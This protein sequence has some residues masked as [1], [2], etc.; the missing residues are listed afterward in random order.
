[1]KYI[2]KMTYNGKGV[3]EDSIEEYM[4]TMTSD[5]YFIS[6]LYKAF[7]EGC[8]VVTQCQH[9]KAIPFAEEFKATKSPDVIYTKMNIEAAYRAGAKKMAEEWEK[10]RAVITKKKVEKASKLICACSQLMTIADNFNKEAERLMSHDLMGF[11]VKNNHIDLKG[12]FDE[13]I[14]DF[15]KW[16][17]SC[18]DIFLNLSVDD[19][20]RWGDENERLERSVRKIMKID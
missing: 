4:R 12:K 6:D 2:N 5:V 19:S 11:E 15:R 9:E 17:E 20:F 1:M 3:F 14:E 7:I 8:N 13:L 18:A 10:S 16:N